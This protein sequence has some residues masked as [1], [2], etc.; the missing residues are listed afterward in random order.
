MQKRPLN[1]KL[2]FITITISKIVLRAQGNKKKVMKKHKKILNLKRMKIKI[3]L[4][5]MK[6]K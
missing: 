4:Q 2:A 6:M 1:L 5:M 3:I